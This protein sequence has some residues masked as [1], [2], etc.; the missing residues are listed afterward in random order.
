MF[1]I[2]AK[3]CKV[4]NVE[5]KDKM[6]LVDLSVSKKN[7][8]GTYTNSNYKKCKFVGKHVD[9]ARTLVKG[10]VINVTNGLIGKREYDKKYYDDVVIFGFEIEKKVEAKE[11]TYN[12]DD[13][14]EIDEDMDSIPF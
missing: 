4:W 10:D 9:D 11:E 7:Q 2:T 14:M 12:A 1:N 8:D 3:Y 6:V 13:F 5:V